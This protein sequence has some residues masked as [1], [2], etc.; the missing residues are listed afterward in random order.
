M[1]DERRFSEEEV[2]EIFE[3]AASPR[4]EPGSA[5]ARTDGLTLGELQAIGAEVGLPPERIAEAAAALDVRREGTRRVSLGMPISVRRTL[6]LP[7]APS[8]REWEMLVAE[9]RET[10]GA[11]GREG[12]RGEVREWSNGNLHA[13][14]EPTETGY[15]LRMGTTKGDA[16][17]LNRFGG[18]SLVMSLATLLLILLLGRVGEDFIIPVLF[19][20]AG[21]L[22]LAG[23]A[24]R[25]PSWAD[26]RERQMEQI[27]AR[28]T[29]L[30]SGPSGGEA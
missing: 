13:Y 9:L 8:D 5:V 6:E 21:G 1:P 19:A 7:R 18:F 30:L 25:L 14:V 12:S 2:A 16:E 3:A 27:A 17:A 15:R 29:A 22:A 11:R 10:F 20:L 28:A 4:Q 23:N 24:A 26:Q